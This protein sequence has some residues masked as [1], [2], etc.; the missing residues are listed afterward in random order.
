MQH[1]RTAHAG[2]MRQPAQR[3]RG[4]GRGRGMARGAR[5]ATMSRRIERGTDVVM[6]ANS[7]SPTSLTGT[8]IAQFDINP[9][10][11]QDTR[12]CSVATLWTRWR[13]VKFEI[14]IQPSAGAMTSGTYSAGFTFDTDLVF[15]NGKHLVP[16]VNAM[17]P[18][19]TQTIYTKHRLNLPNEPT[20]R[21]YHVRGR[22]RQDM[23]HGRVLVVLSSQ[24][25]NITSPSKVEFTFKITWAIEFDGPALPTAQ[26]EEHVYCDPGY[27]GYHTTSTN[28]WANGTKLSVKHTA[29]G[30]LVPFSRLQTGVI[31]KIDPA[32]N[33]PYTAKGKGKDAANTTEKVVYGVAITNFGNNKNM[34]VFKEL[35]YATE[36]AKTQSVSY[37]LE[38]IEAGAAVSPDNPVW[39]KVDSATIKIAQLEEII[40][41]LR[42]SQPSE[43]A[44][45]S[46]SFDDLQ[47][48]DF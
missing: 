33:L 48:Q 7:I 23:V 18:S 27:E 45:S 3:G 32:A 20:Q 6:G 19:S 10:M 43:Q 40:R 4:R 38:Y 30:A 1:K 21:W 46:S 2:Q 37:C 31:Y 29:G 26:Q 25:G 14:D 22:E 8:V 36:F 44:S 13:P 24:I 34:A 17:V 11:F 16:V 5:T 47:T 41:K 28:D 9:E 12:L 42:L 15:S 39:V 35:A